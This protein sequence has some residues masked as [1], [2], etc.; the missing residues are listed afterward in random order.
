MD[1]PTKLTVD[2]IQLEII[3]DTPKE[4]GIADLEI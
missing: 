3:R 2:P 4:I 1:M